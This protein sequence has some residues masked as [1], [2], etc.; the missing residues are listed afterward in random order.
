MN[1]DGENFGERNIIK[2]VFKVLK[3][4]MKNFAH[5]VFAS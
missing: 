4:D 5:K 3:I 2:N 1:F